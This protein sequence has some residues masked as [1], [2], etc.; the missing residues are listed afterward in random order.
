MAKILYINKS[1][2]NKQLFFYF[3]YKFYLKN[4]DIFFLYLSR[5]IIGFSTII[6]DLRPEIKFKCMS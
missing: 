3:F 4:L 6:I 2:G 1:L 5:E